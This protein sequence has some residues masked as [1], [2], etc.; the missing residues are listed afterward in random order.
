MPWTW[1]PWVILNPR[2]YID[3]IDQDNQ[4]L[5]WMFV[6]LAHNCGFYFKFCL[7]RGGGVLGV[8][9]DIVCSDVFC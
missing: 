8:N 2:V 6:G 4:I 1:V 3:P 5:I 7:L 9:H